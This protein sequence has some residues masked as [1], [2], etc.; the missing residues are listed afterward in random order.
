MS[1]NRRQFLATGAA[2]SAAPFI[3][4]CSDVAKGLPRGSRIAVIGAGFA[5]LTAARRLVD[6]GYE[7]TV[8]EARDRFGGRAFTKMD[9]GTPVDLG[10]SWLHGGAGNPLKPI[11]SEAKIPS[12]ESDY[13]N[14]DVWQIDQAEATAHSIQNIVGG[15]A[16]KALEKAAYWPAFRHVIWR[17][18][19]LSVSETSLA[20]IF[21]QANVN[22]NGQLPIESIVV[23][24]AMESMYASPLEKLGLANFL[25]ASATDAQDDGMIDGATNEW[26]MTGGM[27]NLLAS[28]AG[29]LDIRYSEPITQVS[30]DAKG[31]M[32]SSAQAD[33]S[34]DAVI[35]TTSVGVLQQGSIKF[36]PPLPETHQSALRF[37][38]MG[39]MNKVA[40]QF[41]SATWP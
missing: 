36:E 12:T 7:V 34:A 25:V 16:S 2:M 4:G 1:L 41:P 10:A 28:V 18:L 5:G 14:A 38:D 15:P 37:I 19:G 6:A 22:Y 11:A 29:E 23:R 17:S 32:V 39:T 30:Y 35:V 27:A 33:Y 40:L 3:Q 20:T 24:L 31:T 26:F 13:G 21:E 9:L 8:F